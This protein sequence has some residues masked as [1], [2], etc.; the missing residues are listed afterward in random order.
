MGWITR[1]ARAALALGA[2][3][4]TLFVP[5]RATGAE[6]RVTI[7]WSAPG[8]CPDEAALLR[9]VHDLVGAGVDLDAEG[10]MT[11]NDGRYRVTLRVTTGAS[12]GE[13]E[14]EGD[15]CTELA[16]SAAV[17]LALS[18]TQPERATPI[19]PPAPPPAIPAPLPVSHPSAET[20]PKTHSVAT[21]RDPRAP[22]VRVMP[23]GSMDV[24]TLPKPAFGGGVDLTFLPGRSVRLGIKGALWG[25]DSGSTSTLTG[26]AG[27]RF[28]L[29]TGDAE[30]C[31]AFHARS[32][33]LSPCVMVEIAH[34]WA[35]GYDV[36]QSDSSQ[37]TWVAL[38]VGVRGRWELTRSFA[39]SAELGG[40]VPTQGQSFV[41]KDEP[42]P[43]V[44]V[45]VV[46][47]VALRVYLGPEVR[48]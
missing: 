13:R 44:T 47:P 9:T 32:F 7:R 25:S 35:T 36:T 26:S 1:H 12:R 19:A 17:V 21:E 46:G 4:A 48:F 29:F 42:A 11:A 28:E 37:A 2:T 8:G 18:A 20:A 22:H 41:I 5:L 43:D 33:E 24:G 31:Y 14:L 16:E 3:M 40:V 30:G 27:A 15:S 10:V 45:H 6:P 38:G 23:F 34:L 39:V